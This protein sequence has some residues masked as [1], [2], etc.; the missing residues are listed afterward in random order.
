MKGG[1]VGVEGCVD[2][3]GGGFTRFEEEEE[4]QRKR[5][6]KCKESPKW[7]KIQGWIPK[8]WKFRN[9]MKIN[10]GRSSKKWGKEGRK[11]NCRDEK[12][13]ALKLN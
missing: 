3:F 1:W 13:E 12:E 5:G 8:N 10:K 4:E 11:E 9:K 7:A 2:D 6:S